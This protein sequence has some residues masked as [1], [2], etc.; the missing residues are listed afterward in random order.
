MSF[1]K[2]QSIGFV[3]VSKVSPNKGP[4]LGLKTGSLS[5]LGIP[6]PG[7]GSDSLESAPA[8]DPSGRL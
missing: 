8:L 3:S 2:I 1:F 4:P 5:P 7:A 6:G